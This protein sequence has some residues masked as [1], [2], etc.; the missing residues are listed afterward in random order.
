MAGEAPE[1]RA[2]AKSI[3]VRT[4]RRFDTVMTAHARKQDQRYTYGDLL[5]WPQE[6]R[7]ELIEGVPC[8]MTAP[9][10]KHQRISSE[11][12]RQLGNYLMDRSCE[13]YAAPFDVRLPEGDEKDEDIQTVVQPDLLV[14]CDEQ[15]LD[16]LG[17]RGAPDLIIEIT[18]PSTGSQ[19]HIRKLKLYEKHGVREYWI[20]QPEEKIVMVRVLAADGTYGKA[21]LYSAED[22]APVAVLPG[23]SLDLTLVFRK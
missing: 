21:A 18:S 7:W 20:I 13:V 16:E 10:R 8:N 1:S 5:L 12:V 22:Q 6:E 23:F 9:R 3:D 15:K 11:L 14:V 4:E 2:A 17:C 19:D